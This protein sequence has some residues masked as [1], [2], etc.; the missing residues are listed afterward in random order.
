MPVPLETN[1]VAIS[2]PL[3]SGKNLL[4]RRKVSYRYISQKKNPGYQSP[5]PAS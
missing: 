2:E 3:G 1:K 4:T 5:Q